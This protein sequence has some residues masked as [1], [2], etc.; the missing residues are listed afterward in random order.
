M[1]MDTSSGEREGERDDM[2]M[3]ASSGERE[4]EGMLLSKSWPHLPSK[5]TA[6]RRVASVPFS[7]V[8]GITGEGAAC[9]P[10]NTSA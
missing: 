5:Q 4:G 3:D 7:N 6:P 10:A 8:K 1:S 9:N 2:G